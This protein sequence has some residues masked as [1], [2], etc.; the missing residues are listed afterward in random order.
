MSHVYGYIELD[1]P[2]E[3]K[4]TFVGVSRPWNILTWLFVY[5][6]LT[7][8]ARGTMAIMAISFEK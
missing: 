4:K 5:I 1:Y 6:P 2:D 3:G 8:L 7:P